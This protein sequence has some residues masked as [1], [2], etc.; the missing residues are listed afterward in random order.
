MIKKPETRK[1][2][3]D[4][5]G[6]KP[7][8]L[9]TWERRFPDL[10]ES[11]PGEKGNATPRRYTESDLIVF[12]A[13]KNLRNRNVTLKQ[14]EAKPELLENEIEQTTL[15]QWGGEETPEQQA[16]SLAIV[17]EKLTRQLLEYSNRAGELAGELNRANEDAERYRNLYEETLERAIIAETANKDRTP[18]EPPETPPEPAQEP[19]ED[20]GDGDIETEPETEKPLTI[21][22]RFKVLF[23]GKTS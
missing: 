14:I 12:L 13:I 4:W 2:I 19:P 23:T 21:S 22:Q 8:T 6:V 7:P 17:N 5:L 3:F 16:S 1:E 18:Q 9:R 15:P 10:I 20:S 11:P